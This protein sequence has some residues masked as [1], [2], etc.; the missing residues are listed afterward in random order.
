MCLPFRPVSKTYYSSS[1]STIVTRM[2]NCILLFVFILLVYLL[3]SA[4]RLQSK[5]SIHAYFSSSD[6]DQ[7]QSPTKIEHIVFGIGSSAISWRARREYVKLWWDAQKMRG[8]VFVERPLPSSQNHTDSYL[9]PPV[10][11]SQD[12]SRFR[13]TWRGGD[14]NAIRIARCVL[15]TVRLFNT[16]SEEVRWYVF[17]DDDTIFIPENLARTLSK[18]DHT[19]WYYIGSTSEIYHQNSMFGHDMAF[20]GG[21]YALSSSLANVL[22]RNFDSCIER[23]PHLYGGDSRVYACVLELG[24]GLSKEPGF[25]QFDVRGNALG[26]LTSHSTRPLVSLHHMA[27][28]DPIFPNSTTFSAVRHLFS[29][30]QL[31][32]LRIF[33]LSV[34]YDRWYS[35]TI[36]VSWGY[37]VQIDGRHLFLRD[38]LR[39]QETFR[40]WQKSGGLASVYTF[41]TREIHRDPCQRPVTFYMQHVSS[42]SHDGTIKSVYKQA[43][44]NCTYDPVTSPRKIHE[45]RVF[46]RRLDPNIR[47]LK[48][49]RRQCCDILPTSSTGGNIMEIGLRECKEDELIYIHP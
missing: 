33:Q 29:A 15:E 28:I 31:D 48:A 45:I 1:S 43:Y 25:H 6:Q 35:W 34:C 49:P 20:G 17:G 44:E 21:G 39:A 4:S 42:S 8:C 40:P 11:V 46:S 24:V 5:N 47:Q 3:I 30:V 41:N 37:T 16:S 14:R 38:V 2:V 26:I 7:S 10:C 18:Y 27:H 9:L 19:S 12:T 32:P 23:Y 36:S 13:Y 22:A